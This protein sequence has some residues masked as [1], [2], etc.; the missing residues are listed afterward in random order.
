MNCAQA[1]E[2]VDAFVDGELDAA[3]RA[4]VEAHAASCPAC[5][6]RLRERRSLSA[7]VRTASYHR[8]SADLRADVLR[9]L[10]GE[11]APRVSFWRGNVFSGLAG[12]AVG[13]ACALFVLRAPPP[14]PPDEEIALHAA[15]LTVGPLVAVRSSDHH[16]VKPW[17]SRHLDFSPP[18]P[19]LAAQGFPL[20]GGRAETLRAGP[21]AVL[22]YMRRLHVIDVYVRPDAGPDA[23]VSAAPDQRG[24][25]VLSWR[26]RGFAFRAVSDV[27]AAELADFAALLRAAP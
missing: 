27:N 8:A 12:A 10:R 4:A 16:Q 25:H 24:Y 19:D 21:A 17:F 2:R 7:A 6:A 11:S 23:P 9:S 15:A 26:S 22:V 20:A 1:L 13:F 14:A 3:E 5:A 18:V